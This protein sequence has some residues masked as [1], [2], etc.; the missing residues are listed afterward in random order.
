MPPF[1]RIP[2]QPLKSKGNV[3]SGHHGHFGV[4]FNKQRASQN[5]KMQLVSIVFTSL[6]NNN[7]ALNGEQKNAHHATSQL[8]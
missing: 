7:Q 4:K 3:F 2:Q 5:T 1:G 8:H 6:V